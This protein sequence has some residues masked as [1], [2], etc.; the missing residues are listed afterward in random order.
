MNSIYTV[1]KPQAVN[2]ILAIFDTEKAAYDYVDYLNNARPSENSYVEAHNILFDH[3]I[4]KLIREGN[5]YE[6]I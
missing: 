3:R 5:N 4:L 1:I 2:A 6:P